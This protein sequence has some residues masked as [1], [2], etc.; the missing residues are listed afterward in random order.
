MKD[1]KVGFIGCGGNSRRHMRDLSKLSYAKLVAFC[2]VVEDKAKEVADERGGSAY[3]DFNDMFAKQD[4]DAVYISIPCD[5]HGAPERAALEAGVPMFVEK[6]VH[7]DMG[8]AKEIATEVEAKGLITSAGYQERYIDVIDKATAALEDRKVG[9]LM[10]YWMGGTPKLPWWVIKAKSGGQ[11]VEQT[12]HMFDMARYLCGDVTRVYAGAVK[13][14]IQGVP[15]YDIEDASAV[16]L[17]FESGALGVIYSAC[18]FTGA[19]NVPAGIDVFTPDMTINYKRRKSVTLAGAHGVETF[20]NKNEYCLDCDKGFIDAV[21][22]GDSST[23]RITYPS[24]VKSLELS[25]AANQSLD[26]GLPVDLPM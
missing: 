20:E 5:C 14:I 9:I 12:T 7:L 23:V 16:T 1:V 8:E 6:P 11:Q 19:K 26:T 15:N 22:A 13:G 3:T 21:R 10:G 4:L 24:A 25:L 2:D 18:Y 17:F